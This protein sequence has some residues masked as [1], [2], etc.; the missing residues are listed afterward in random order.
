MKSK[1]L[2][3]FLIIAIVI[4]GLNGTDIANRIFGISDVEQT[5]VSKN[6][7]KTDAVYISSYDEIS[8]DPMKIIDYPSRQSTFINP[9][10][11]IVFGFSSLSPFTMSD[12]LEILIQNISLYSDKTTYA[13]PADMDISKMTYVDSHD[14]FFIE[15]H[16]YYNTK[17]EERYVDMIFDSSS[18]EII[19]L[20][21]YDDT[22]YNPTSAQ[23][24]KGISR[25]QEYSNAYFDS[26]NEYHDIDNWIFHS[27]DVP[28][29]YID[30]EPVFHFNAT[31]FEAKEILAAYISSACRNANTASK[32]SG[33]SNPV[34]KFFMNVTAPSLITFEDDIAYGEKFYGNINY[35]APF[36]TTFQV[37][38]SYNLFYDVIDS[39]ASSYANGEYDIKYG[40]SS[41]YDNAEYAPYNGRIYQTIRT[42][43]SEKFVIIYNIVTNEIEGFYIKPIERLW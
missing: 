23:V 3:T 25:L 39:G 13:E 36:I 40:A 8:F 27:Y 29:G 34:I 20:N 24:Q 4:I 2:F 11:D 32:I 22:E 18:F 15:K 19:Y 28:Y 6:S 12:M 7:I 41:P 30:E 16:K 43:N 37:L 31:L 9:S 1:I 10:R 14:Y 26:I 17:H 33:G 5:A 42:N 21:F 35:D 38:N